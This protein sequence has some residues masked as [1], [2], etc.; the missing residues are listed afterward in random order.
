M[1]GRNELESLARQS[2]ALWILLGN[3]REYVELTEDVVPAQAAEKLR[4]Y[5][6]S[7]QEN[8][9]YAKQQY[10]GEKWREYFDL[11]NELRRD[12]QFEREV[13]ATQA[14]RI[15]KRL[16]ALKEPSLV[17]DTSNLPNAE[18]LARI[19][20]SR[21]NTKLWGAIF[22]STILFVGLVITRIGVKKIEALEEYEFENRSANGAVEFPTFQDSKRHE[23]QWHRAEAIRNIGSTILILGVLAIMLFYVV[24]FT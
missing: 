18:D 3:A 5:R 8:Y 13:L 23:R 16:N 19:K 14:P 11:S 10:S 22:A 2:A 1:S 20:G 17:V 15:A 7:I 6:A 21:A 12:R 9:S 24:N 4:N